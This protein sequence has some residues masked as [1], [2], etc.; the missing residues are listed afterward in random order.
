MKD[1]TNR[2]FWEK[3]AGIYGKAMSKSGKLYDEICDLIRPGLSSDMNVLEIGCGTGQLSYP[4]SGRVRLWEATDFSP[5]MIREAKR[6]NDSKKLHFTVADAICLPY[7]DETFDAVVIANTL[8][9]MPHPELALREIHRVLKKDGMLYAPTFLKGKCF[10]ARLRIRIMELAGFHV[11]H[12]WNEWELAG[13]VKENGFDRIRYKVIGP[14]ISR[15][16]YL[17]ARRREV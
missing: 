13:N 9:I 14:D 16:C 2:F 7:G 11:F 15:L 12:N 4:L 17:E 3:I 10:S 5:A 8:H 6:N 1:E